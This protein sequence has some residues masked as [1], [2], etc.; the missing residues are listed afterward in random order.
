M[1]GSHTFQAVKPILKYFDQLQNEQHKF[2]NKQKEINDMQEKIQQMQLTI[3]E[4]K[5]KDDV[6]VLLKSAGLSKDTHIKDLQTTISELQ[7][8]NHI[9]KQIVE[10]LNK[11]IAQ[12]KT[13]IKEE[14]NK[15][16][17][18]I[19][20]QN[21]VS[22]YAAT[23]SELKAQIKSNDQSLKECQTK[24]SE[25]QTEV[26]EQQK[27]E[28]SKLNEQLVE[29]GEISVG[30]I[31]YPTSN[32]IHNV[33]IPGFHTFPALCDSVIAGQGWTVI[34][35]RINGKEFYQIMGWI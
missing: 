14:L 28:V 23:I 13:C 3:T 16:L 30:C 29:N 35:Q 18:K 22:Q 10:S 9:L 12:H 33:K 7:N 26:I 19:E 6:I 17:S 24:L 11:E 34:Q 20:L 31:N 21:T 25:K 5:L 15:E 8:I 27:Q 2:E 4:G 1:C 32:E